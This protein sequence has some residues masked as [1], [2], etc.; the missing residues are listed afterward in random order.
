MPSKK[1]STYTE[2]IGLG[3]ICVILHEDLRIFHNVELEIYLEDGKK[4]ISCSGS[5]MWV[6]KRTDARGKVSYD[7][8]IEFSNLD[9]EGTARITA[10]VEE[11]LKKEG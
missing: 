8:G 7:T 6:V 4:P 11:I 5:I 1:A 9:K 2:N 10:I 3:G